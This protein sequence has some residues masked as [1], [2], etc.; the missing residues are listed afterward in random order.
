MS[1]SK[2]EVINLDEI[3]AKLQKS[4][5]MIANND[6]SSMLMRIKI[7]FLLNETAKQSTF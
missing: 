1:L 6:G 5:K 7:S 2:K 3:T 4:K